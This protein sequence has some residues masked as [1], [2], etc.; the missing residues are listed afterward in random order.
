MCGQKQSWFELHL[1]L[2]EHC[3]RTDEFE[4]LVKRAIGDFAKFAQFSRACHYGPTLGG[5]N[6]MSDNQVYE[7]AAVIEIFLVLL[8]SCGHTSLLPVGGSQLSQ[9][10]AVFACA[11]LIE[12]CRNLVRLRRHRALAR[13]DLF[14][15]LDTAHSHKCACHEPRTSSR[16]R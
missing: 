1:F 11:H 9:I 12:K 13:E 6:L 14:G 15:K 16:R 2:C 4:L 8:E 5:A 7:W 10:G 3:L